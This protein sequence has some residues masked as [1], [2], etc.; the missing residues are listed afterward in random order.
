MI[1]ESENSSRQFG[2]SRWRFLLVAA[3]VVCCAGAL[4]A[5][6][7]GKAKPGASSAALSANQVAARV[8]RHYN[9]LRSLEML[10]GPIEPPR[11]DMR[12]VGAFVWLRCRDA[13]FW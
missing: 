6:S 2:I 13:G 7:G 11:A 5:Q 9:A 3:L 12:E 1:I 8:D 4:R 10:P